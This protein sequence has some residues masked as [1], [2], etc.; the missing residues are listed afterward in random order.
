MILA[1]P[2]DLGLLATPRLLATIVR[3]NRKLVLVL[4]RSRGETAASSASTLGLRVVVVRAAIDGR[5]KTTGS[6]KLQRE[7]REVRDDDG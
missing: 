1:K 6:G 4:V 2:T 7:R 3:Q 5:R